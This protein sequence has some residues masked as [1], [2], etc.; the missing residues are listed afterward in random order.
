MVEQLS[1]DKPEMTST[2]HFEV[3]HAQLA[4]FASVLPQPFN[5]WS[6]R[7]VRQGFSWRPGSVSFRTVAES[8]PHSVEIQVVDHAAALHP[9]AVR[10]VKVPFQV[11]DGAVEVGC[12]AE[13]VPLSLPPG[14][15]LLRCEFLQ[16]ADRH[17]ARVRLV[18]ARKDAPCFAILRADP[19]LSVPGNC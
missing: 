6:E 16:P 19:A 13:T 2:V 1:S 7:H 18:F 17:G 3:S 12:I 4:V 11:E 5:D 14:S 15:F 8:G 9:D 10:A